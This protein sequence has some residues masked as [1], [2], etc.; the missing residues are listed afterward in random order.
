MSLFCKFAQERFPGVETLRNFYDVFYGDKN[1]PE[2]IQ[3]NGANLKSIEKMYIHHA[4]NPPLFAWAEY[5][6]ALIHGD[7]DYLKDLLYNRQ[8]LQKHYNWI[9]SLKE[10]TLLPNVAK[11]TNL[12]CVDNGYKWAGYPS[13]M[14]NTPRG[15]T[16]AYAEKE[17]PDNPD[18]LW[19]DAI[20]QQALSAKCISALFDLLEDTEKANEWNEK[21]L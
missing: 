13:G 16:T 5:E 21:Y 14:D 8:A 1:L 3:T 10:D 7:K 19:I 9:E 12:K 2:I 11:P 20:C 18:M 15:K 4:D 6:N 17:R